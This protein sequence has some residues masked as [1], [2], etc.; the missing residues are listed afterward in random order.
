[1]VAIHVLAAK[2]LKQ[3]RE[4]MTIFV[5]RGKKL[6]TFHIFLDFLISDGETFIVDHNIN[7]TGKLPSMPL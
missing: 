6:T 2:V 7:D 3:I 5:N 4:Q 1:M